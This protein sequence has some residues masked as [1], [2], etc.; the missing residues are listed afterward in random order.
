MTNWTFLQV[1]ANFATIANAL[2]LRRMGSALVIPAYK[3]IHLHTQVDRLLNVQYMLTK[4][5]F[6]D[7]YDRLTLADRHR[8]ISAL[9][10]CVLTPWYAQL[11]FLIV[12]LSRLDDDIRD[13]HNRYLALSTLGWLQYSTE[14]YNLHIVVR[15]LLKRLEEVRREIEVCRLCLANAFYH[16]VR[17][18]LTL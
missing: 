7:N 2:A 16:S 13:C 5:V 10:R 18:V 15:A 9:G 17:L 6:P 3:A 12:V 11:W 14:V 1:A 4:V 8:A